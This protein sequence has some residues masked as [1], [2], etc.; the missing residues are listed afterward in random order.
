MSNEVPLQPVPSCPEFFRR[1]NPWKAPVVPLLQVNGPDA[2]HPAGVTLR[3]L[4]CLAGRHRDPHGRD[5]DRRQASLAGLGLSYEG[6]E[7]CLFIRVQEYCHC[8]AFSANI[9]PGCAKPGRDS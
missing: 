1:D 6:L 3:D 5:A 4:E 8:R 9:A 2:R 7:D